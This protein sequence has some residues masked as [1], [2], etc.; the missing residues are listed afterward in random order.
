MANRSR[1]QEWRGAKKCYYCDQSGHI[2]KHCP[3]KEQLCCYQC[4]EKGHKKR[5]CPQR[6]TDVKLQQDRATHSV[7]PV[8]SR[9]TTRDGHAAAAAGIQ[10]ATGGQQ[11]HSKGGGKVE[12]GAG[13]G[14]GGEERAEPGKASRVWHESKEKGSASGS[15]VANSDN[16][17]THSGDGA[18]KSPDHCQSQQNG[19]ARHSNPRRGGGG[20]YARYSSIPVYV[21]THCH[22]EYILQQTYINHY[23]DLRSRFRYP[24]NFRGCITSFCDP[25]AFSSFGMWQELVEED[26]VWGTFGVHP[27]HARAYSDKMEERIMTCLGHNKCVGFGEMGLDYSTHCTAESPRDVQKRVLSR[28]L[29]LAPAMCKPLVL[30]C[31]DAEEDLLECL[32]TAGVPRDWKIHLHCYSGSWRTAQHFIDTFPNSYFGFTGHITYRTS[33]E[34]KL[35]ATNVPADRL[36]LETDSPYLTPAFFKDRNIR[37]CHPPMA[38]A[39]VHELAEV[40]EEPVTQLA[41]QL[42]KNCESFYG[43]KV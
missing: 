29:S 26:G 40:R 22:L 4:G 36:L 20:L 8:E 6:A 23:S 13:K 39:V 27:R 21:D 25:G 34:T 10:H 1:A 31:R 42:Q 33:D 9:S 35:V 17:V 15:L 14:G 37:H 3:K 19:E 11:I 41:T 5:D 43:I 7:E 2:A 30:H 38:G 12:V 18:T 16:P 24:D 28:L 32:T